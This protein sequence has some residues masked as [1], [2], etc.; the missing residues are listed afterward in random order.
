MLN[1]GVRFFF[2]MNIKFFGN[3]FCVLILTLIVINQ[4]NAFDTDTLRVSQLLLKVADLRQKNPDS[5][6]VYVDEAYQLA[7]SLNDEEWIGR[8]LYFKGILQFVGGHYPESLSSY[9]RALDLFTKKKL[10][11]RIPPLLANI[12]MIYSRTGD[13]E[14]AVNYYLQALK[15][16]EGMSDQQLQGK[17]YNSLGIISKQQSNYKEAIQYYN[18]AFALFK[19][20]NNQL[21]VAGTYTN[22]SNVYIKSGRLDSSILINKKALSIFDSLGNQRGKVTCYNNLAEAYR[23]LNDNPSALTYLTMS[24]KVSSSQKALRS[25]YIIAQTELGNVQVAMGIYRKQNAI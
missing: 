14:T 1:S 12:G 20:M 2:V 5:A 15:L 7:E 23:L 3:L 25:N 22:L 13:Y 21:E 8:S 17:I 24:L 19:A 18:K 10:Q 16:A 4:A 9:Q 11:T 6:M